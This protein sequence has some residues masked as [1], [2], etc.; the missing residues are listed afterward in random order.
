MTRDPGARRLR[1]MA[2]RDPDRVP[3]HALALTSS[4][5]R[6]TLSGGFPRPA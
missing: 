4:V 6:L 2:R 5:V 1:P 3:L